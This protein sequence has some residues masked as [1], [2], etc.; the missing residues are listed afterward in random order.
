MSIDLTGV[1]DFISTLSSQGAAW[2][3]GLTGTPVVVP[4]T[5]AAI[6]AQQQVALNQAAQANLN[7]TN[8]VLSG[9]LA[10]PAALIIIGLVL[11]IGAIFLLRR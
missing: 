10:N 6:A 2:Y 5:T 9:I 4:A 11:L 1:S 3:R 8:P 7:V